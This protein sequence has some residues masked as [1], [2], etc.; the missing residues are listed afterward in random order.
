[1][2]LKIIRN[3]E[4]EAFERVGWVQRADIRRI[5]LSG[6][7]MVQWAGEGEPINPE[8]PVIKPIRRGRVRASA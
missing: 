2:S 1:M 4:I 3:S 8:L 5:C 6:W 7:V